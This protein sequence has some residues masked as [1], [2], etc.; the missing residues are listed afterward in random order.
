MFGLDGDRSKV[1]SLTDCI[2]FRFVPIINGLAFFFLVEELPKG[3]R[4]D[5]P[6]EFSLLFGG[7]LVAYLRYVVLMNSMSL[8]VVPVF[9]ANLD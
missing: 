7:L 3:G 6:K 8:T 9:P 2:L 5:P 4:L 1:R